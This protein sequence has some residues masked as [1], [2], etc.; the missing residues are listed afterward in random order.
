[1]ISVFTNVK[2]PAPVAEVSPEYI[3]KTIK[4]PQSKYIEHIHRLRQYEK[5]HPIYED[6]KRLK[7]PSITWCGTFKRRNKSSLIE[8][9]NYLYFD[10]DVEDALDK[11]P[12]IVAQDVV[13]ACWVSSGGKGLGFLVESKGINK[14]NFKSTYDSL[15]HKFNDLGVPIDKLSDYTR[16]NIMSFDPDIYVNPTSEIYP[17]QEPMAKEEVLKSFHKFIPE[18]EDDYN[19]K[20]M[21]VALNYTVFHKG[22]FIPGFRHHFTVS[23]A[24]LCNQFGVPATEAYLFLFRRG[25][26]SDVTL[27][28]INDIYRRYS[29]QFGQS[30]LYNETK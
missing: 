14:G 22:S 15:R 12:L 2:T 8:F 27:K 20:C 17:S 16:C 24:G 30:V 7:L 23:Y 11:K 18:E 1:M 5:G 6:I 10:V 26:Y 3:F 28:K 4:D 21:I 9:S 13:R 25:M 19:T 29:H